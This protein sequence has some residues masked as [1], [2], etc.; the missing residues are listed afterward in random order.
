MGVTQRESC[1]QMA[2]TQRELPTDGNN[3]ERERELPTDGHNSERELPT[4]S[5]NSERAAYHTYT[6]I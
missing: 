5:H 6:N 4:Y 1:L 3:S 2:I